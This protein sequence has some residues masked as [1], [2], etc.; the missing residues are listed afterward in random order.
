MM[1]IQK[2]NYFKKNKKNLQLFVKVSN[3]VKKILTIKGVEVLYVFKRPKAYIT[4][5]DDVNYLVLLN[6][7]V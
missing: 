7:L 3:C 2:C 1:T 5:A 6:L 4:V